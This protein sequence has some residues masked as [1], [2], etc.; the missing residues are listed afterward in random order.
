M[1]KLIV[2]CRRRNV[3]QFALCFVLIF[4]PLIVSAK[5]FEEIIEDRFITLEELGFDFFIPLESCDG[6]H[7]TY[8]DTRAFFVPC[9]GSQQLFIIKPKVSSF[10]S[11]VLRVDFD[12]RTKFV[13]AEISIV[14]NNT[15]VY[16]AVD[17]MVDSCGENTVRVFFT[18]SDIQAPKV[19]INTSRGLALRPSLNVSFSGL[20]NVSKNKPFFVDLSAT[21]LAGVPVKNISFRVR[22]DVGDVFS[23]VVDFSPREKKVFRLNF[24]DTSHDVSSLRVDY[25]ERFYGDSRDVGYPFFSSVEERVSFKRDEESLAGDVTLAG[26][27]DDSGTDRTKQSSTLEPNYV[28]EFLCAFGFCDC[29]CMIGAYCGK[30]ECCSDEQCTSRHCDLNLNKCLLESECKSL[31]KKGN[32]VSKLDLVI[33]GDGY[34]DYS[35]LESD[36]NAVL[37]FDDDGQ[38]HGLFSTNVFKANKHTFNIWL[39]IP[40]EELPRLTLNGKPLKEMEEMP[41]FSSVRELVK[42]KCAHF[43][44]TMILSKRGF[45]SAAIHGQMG[46]VSLGGWLNRLEDCLPGLACHGRVFA[47][48]FGHAFAGLNDEYVEDGKRD[49]SRKPNCAPDNE[50]AISWWGDI[51]KKAPKIGFYQGCAYVEKN[52]RPTSNSIMREHWEENDDY[53]EVNEKRILERLSKYN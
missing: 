1:S 4:F 2:S 30:V 44:K 35:N 20:K 29:K 37:D 52:V 14:S 53:Y 21:E 47:H 41:S 49:R 15:V 17:S 13:P 10:N 39:L 9:S 18:F 32:S 24:S 27:I 26:K 40:E 28:G 33:V 36:A 23:T 25:R 7:C 16:D 8:S 5:T 6:S 31:V 51:A 34:F 50:T 3:V 48:E 38:Y 46:A 11:V 22:T 45:R 19:L 43:D 42:T 12:W